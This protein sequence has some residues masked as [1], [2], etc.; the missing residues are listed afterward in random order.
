MRLTLIEQEYSQ[1]TLETVFVA[2]NSTIHDA[3]WHK[4]ALGFKNTIESKNEARRLSEKEAQQTL[5]IPERLCDAIYGK[6]IELIEGAHPHRHLIAN[7]EKALQDNYL[8]SKRIVDEKVKIGTTFNFMKDDD[9]SIDNNKYAQTIIDNQPQ[10]A[11][12][13]I[14]PLG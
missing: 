5:V 11:S 13:I 8:E 4:L 7:T 3:S 12:N 1:A 14:I 6:A 2:I 10:S 9:G